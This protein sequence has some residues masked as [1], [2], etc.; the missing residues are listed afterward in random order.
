[1]I[2]WLRNDYDKPSVSVDGKILPI[3]IKRHA[4]A[5]RLVLRL[6]PDGS[7]VRLTMPRWGQTREAIEFAQSRVAWLETQLQKAE[8]ARPPVPGSKIPFRGEDLT[9]DWCQRAP[10]RP[11][12]SDRR[13]CLGGAESGMVTRVEKW[14]R[15]Q[16]L[17]IMQ[18]DLA[19][20]CSKAGQALVPLRLSRAQRRWGSCSDSGAVRINWRLIMAPDDVRRSVVAHEVTH[21]VHFDHS[22][23]FHR[24]LEEIFEGD[25]AAANAWLKH[26][27]R[28]LYSHFG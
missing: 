24:L 17:A 7:E 23:A 20:Y 13:L 18:D 6:A 8:Q 10:R 22:P 21:L 11:E 1:M 25:I 12:Y 27:G 16:A 9:I 19:H 14:L 4:R 28:G 2:D 5:K 15:Q 26:N 3:T